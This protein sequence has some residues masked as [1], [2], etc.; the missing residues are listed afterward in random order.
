MPAPIQAVQEITA[1]E[2]RNYRSAR[3]V[4]DGRS[5]LLTGANGAGKTNLLEAVSFL[6]P[7][8]GLRRASLADAV[9]RAPEPPKP[10]G[11]AVAARVTA[12]HG[13]TVALG[14]GID[15]AQPGRRAVRIDGSPV[16]SQAMLA[17]HLA[18]VWL[19]PQMD[20]L[21]LEGSSGRRRFL[22][23]LVFGFDPGHA[24]HLSAYEQ[25]MRERARL[26]RDGRFDD[27]WLAA[28]EG[29][30][31]EN[32]VA[33]AAARCHLTDRLRAAAAVATLADGPFPEADLR[34]QGTVED[35]LADRPALAVEDAVRDGLGERR[36]IDA[37]A[38]VTTEGP[39]RSDLA[40]RH[41]AKDMP[42]DQ[43][44][45][46]E[47]KAL[48]VGLVLANARLMATERGAP[49]VL[50]LDEIAAH[51]DRHRRVAL[52][53]ELRSMGTQAWLTGT[54]PG[55]FGEFL[56]DVVHFTIADGRIGS[57]P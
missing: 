3:I 25:A 18:V 53:T 8:R 17:E 40:V 49:P 27:R 52:F 29:R 23:R 26:L 9:R 32:A 31:A 35:L 50:L 39:H 54:E 34:V 1:T 51:L 45:T 11:W 14:T 56:D 16:S 55:L 33:I 57:P 19:T 2:F 48:L 44:S 13:A 28:L 41:A 24:R 47:Q 43:C 36:A 7:G 21:F 42:A 38:G 4:P 20:R 5:V 22:D 15:P 30:M 37:A 10:Q 46:G 12:G 6:A